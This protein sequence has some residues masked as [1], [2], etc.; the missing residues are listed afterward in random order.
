MS[1][2][3]AVVGAGWYGCHIALSLRSPG[4]AVTV[5]EAASQ[6]LNAASGNNQ[7][8]LHE[9]FH[10]QRH[11]G[12]RLQSRDG[13]HR[14]LE[15][16]EHLTRSVD[17]NVYAV[18]HVD[19]LIDFITYRLIMTATGIEFRE[20]D[21][22][23]VEIVGVEGLILTA[24]RVI[25]LERAREYFSSQ[26]GDDLVLNSRVTC[27]EQDESGLRVEGEPF[28]YMIDA[29]WGHLSPLPIMVRY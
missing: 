17:E 22:C 21:K 29:T 11:F 5:F 2:R 4:S 25:L 23:S 18:P 26:L 14:F 1:L 6:P 16:Y 9:G 7:F 20:I 13:Y 10:Y 24:E 15:R 27:I 19:S 3:L 12:T 28:D 8:R